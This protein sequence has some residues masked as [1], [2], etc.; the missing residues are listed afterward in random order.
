MT[1]RS[2]IRVWMRTGPGT[3]ISMPIEQLSP[4]GRW[5]FLC[6]WFLSIFVPRR[7]R[8]SSTFGAIFG[9]IGL[10]L[11]PFFATYAWIAVYGPLLVDAYHERNILSLV[12]ILAFPALIA[13]VVVSVRMQL[14]HASTPS[15]GPSRATPAPARNSSADTADVPDVS[16]RTDVGTAQHASPEQPTMEAPSVTGQHRS[17]SRQEIAESQ[18][19][20]LQLGYHPGAADG[21]A[22][23]RTRSAVRA[24]QSADS[25]PVTGELDVGTLERLQ[26]RNTRQGKR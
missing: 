7:S 20:L 21:I 12:R 8:K 11:L 5:L 1:R 3:G 24:F 15:A 25:L 17:L 23:Q 2:G 14:D 10:C 16:V 9:I 13:Y 22:G 26:S 18:R 4:L 19:I 6:N